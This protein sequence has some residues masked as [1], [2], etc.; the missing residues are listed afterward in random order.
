MEGPRKTKFPFGTE[1]D[2]RLV[3][4]SSFDDTRRTFIERLVSITHFSFKM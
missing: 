1:H 3:L 2:C 4:I